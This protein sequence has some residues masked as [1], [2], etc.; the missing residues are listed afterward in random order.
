MVGSIPTVAPY[1]LPQLI[2]RCRTEYPHLLVHTREDF[3]PSLLRGVLDGE[4]DLALVS[5]PIKDAHISVEKLY[6]EPLLLAVG[7]GP[8]PRQKGG[9]QRPGSRAR[10]VHSAR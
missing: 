5:L 2:D 3:R 4:L 7:V 1:V 9:G 6:S 8:S 10:D